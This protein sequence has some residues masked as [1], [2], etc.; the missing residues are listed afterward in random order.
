VTVRWALMALVAVLLAS[1]TQPTP[2]SAAAARHVF[3]IVME[4]HTAQ[5]ALDGPFLASFAARYGVAQNYHAVAHPSVPNYLALTSGTTWGVTDDS[6]HVLPRED[7]GD[8]LTSAG[9]TW[10]AYMDS[11]LP[12]RCLDSP[13]PYDPGH[14]PFV[15]Y[16][17]ACPANVVPLTD[18]ASDLNG[19]T[20]RFSWITPD[21]CHDTHSCDVAT[22]DAWLRG[23]V[24]AIMASDAWKSRGVL[25]ITYDEDDESADNHVVTVVAAP[26]LGH[27]VSDRA[28]DHY[29]LLATVE[30]LLGVPR[31]HEAAKAQAM[32]D[33]LP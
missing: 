30:D 12:G 15:F 32:T 1:C 2:G 4:N 19:D 5:Q 25:F 13:L 29:S 27:R 31:L 16:G 20:P 24:E 33:L 18:M 26:E 14:D 22:G 17:G 11:M 9:V 3:V 6:F 23:E 7:I 21:S 10:R 28:Y 8:Q